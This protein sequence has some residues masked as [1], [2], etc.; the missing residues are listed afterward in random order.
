MKKLLYLFVTTLLTVTAGKAQQT[1][2]QLGKSSI[3]EV[4]GAMTLDEKVNL[5]VGGGM[6]A[7]GMPIPGVDMAHPT[8]AQK[9][10]LGAAG[11]IVGVPRLGIP[12]LVVCDGPSGVHPFNM[13]STRSYF[14]TAWP[15]GTLLASSWDTTLVKKVGEAFGKEAKEYGID[16][17]LGPGMNIHRNPLGGRNFEYYSEDPVITGYTAA[18]MIEG[19]QSNG[20]GTAAKHFFAN[21]QETNRNTANTIISERAIREIYLRGWEIAVKKARPW[22]IMSSY[23]LM[24]GP[25]TSENPAL[26]TTVL[27]DEWGFKGFVMTDW[28]GGRNAVAQQFAG[29]NLIMPG[30]QPQKQAILDAVGNGKL[31][32]KILDRNVADILRVILLSPTFGQYKY[33]DH[34]DLTGNALVA[35]QA[36]AESIVLLK[37]NQTLPLP[38]SSTVAVF[39]NNGFQLI[40]GGTG[41]GDVLRMYTVPL[42]DGLYHAGYVVQPDLYLAYSKYLAAESARRPKRSLMEELMAPAPPIDELKV[43]D[44]LIDKA[45]ETS[46]TAIVSIGRN[47]GE[48]SDRPLE[49]N[50]YLTAEERAFINKVATTFHARNKKVVVVLNIAGVIDVAQWRDAVDAIVLAWQPGLEGGNAIA[51]I[52]SG[53]VNP[54]GKLATTFPASYSDDPTAK[55]FPG[56]VFKDKPLQG[57]FGQQAFESEV[58]YEEGVYVGYRYYSTFGVKPAYPFG[59]GLSYTSFLYSNLNLS[60]PAFTNQL[61][62]AVTVTNSGAVPGKEVVQLYLSAPN[63]KLDKPASELKAFAKTRL[64]QPGESQTLTFTLRPRDLSSYQTK[65]TA[66]V[67]DAGTYTVRIGTSDETKLSATFKL[68]K[69]LI[70]EKT[71]NVLAPAQPVNELKPIRKR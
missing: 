57:M 56:K 50:Y 13:G 27:R 30:I 66:W 51:D 22:T 5:L 69:D 71:R 9:R 28:F 32:V 48:G 63:G 21:N 40:A 42:V 26:L 23:N 6:F 53:A 31:D 17:L 44:A 52:L 10:V 70:V 7:P 47:A 54:S 24:N 62:A 2:P 4:V 35:R 41:S 61:T 3:E 38:L 15:T 29:N 65:L 55:N 59:Y 67:A 39:G 34:P 37:N 33:S 46:A 8:D 12:S 60:A 11:T 36:A 1:L 68:P 45:A 16:I 14:A 18:A 20:V 58:V 43:T 64:L 25:M 49:S 19:I